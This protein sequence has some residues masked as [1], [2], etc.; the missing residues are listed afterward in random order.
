[1]AAMAAFE[2]HMDFLTTAVNQLTGPDT[3]CNQITSAIYTAS[4]DRWSECPL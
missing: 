4:G 2:G 1:M 3:H